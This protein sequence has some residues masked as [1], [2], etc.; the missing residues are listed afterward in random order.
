MNLS[1]KQ[2]F[3]FFL[4]IISFILFVSIFKMIDFLSNSNYIVECFTHPFINEAKETSHNVNLPLTTTYSCQNFC[5]PTARCSIT[6]QQCFADIDCPGCQP[7]VPPLPKSNDCIP[8]N[9]DAGKLTWGVTPQY[10]PLTNGY[11]TK[12]LIVTNNVFAKPAMAN[13]GIDTWKDSFNEGDKLFEKR[14][15][16]P[17]NLTYAL[18]YP[19]QYSLTGEFIED[20]PLPSN[21]YLP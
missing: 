12:E 3:I 10:S 19:K 4:V 13:F 9:D 6:G 16:P 2:Y 15:T 20:G 17:N 21:S 14:Y 1:D 5:G 18:N 8:G 7:Y 11:G